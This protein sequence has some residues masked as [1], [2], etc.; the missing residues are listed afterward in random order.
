MFYKLDLFLSSGGRVWSTE[1][2]YLMDVSEP[3]VHHVFTCQQKL[4]QL[5]SIFRT[6]TVCSVL[7]KVLLTASCYD[8]LWNRSGQ[9]FWLKFCHVFQ[10][11]VMYMSNFAGWVPYRY[12]TDTAPVVYREPYSCLYIFPIYVV[13]KVL[14]NSKNNINCNIHVFCP[15]TSLGLQLVFSDLNHQ[16]PKC[17][18]APVPNSL[19]IVLLLVH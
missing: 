2:I 10:C 8:I 12:F 11:W 7:L 6:V 19:N 1:G 4:M 16:V 17:I 14:N 15:C 13:F 18:P 3:F 5:F 9:L